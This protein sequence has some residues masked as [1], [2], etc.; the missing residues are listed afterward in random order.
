MY[1]VHRKSRSAIKR[2]SV[3]VNFWNKKN[4]KYGIKKIFSELQYYKLV[5]FV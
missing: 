1:R 4:L 5:Y 3:I 2:Y